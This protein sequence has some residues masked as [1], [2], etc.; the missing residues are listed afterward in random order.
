MHVMFYS[1]FNKTIQW[2]PASRSAHT[3]TP[4][5]GHLPPLVV[6]RFFFSLFFN[7]PPL[8]ATINNID[9]DWKQTDHLSVWPCLPAELSQ[10]LSVWSW[11]GLSASLADYS[12]RLGWLMAEWYLLSAIDSRS[13]L[14]HFKSLFLYAWTCITVPDQGIIQL[15]E[16]QQGEYLLWLLSEI[17]K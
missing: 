16:T 15:T 12:A 17:S 10:H 1:C 8:P 14:K 5:G 11:S 2:K 9:S 4:V 13:Y 3:Y 7:N 6:S